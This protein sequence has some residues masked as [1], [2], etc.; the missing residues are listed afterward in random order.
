MIGLLEDCGQAS[1]NVDT[2]YI[3]AARDKEK[4]KSNRTA[5]AVLPIYKDGRRGCFFDAASNATFSA[6]HMMDMIKSLSSGSMGPELDT[7]LM[8][9]ADLDNYH[10]DLDQM[11]PTYGAFLFGYPHL[12]PML[13]GEALAQ[14]FLEARNC[15][16]D[17]GIIVLDLNGVPEKKLSTLGLR[18]ISDLRNDLVIGAA[19]DHVVLFFERV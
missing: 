16:I 10:A 19:L 11:T 7:S 8:S 9:A 3:K 1:R 14:V 6:V 13:K 18:S 15:M 2:K 5:L 17:G 12:L 4:E